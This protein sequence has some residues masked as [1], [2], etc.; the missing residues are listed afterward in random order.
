MQN[1]RRFHNQFVTVHPF[2]DGN[3]RPPADL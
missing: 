1:S 2:I 3:G